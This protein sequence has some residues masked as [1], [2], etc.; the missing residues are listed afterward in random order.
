MI[1]IDKIE[2]QELRDQKPANRP[3]GPP[4]EV[5]EVE[6]DVYDRFQTIRSRA[7]PTAYILPPELEE[8]VALL[9]THGIKVEE[10]TDA[11]SGEAEQFLI[12]AHEQRETPYQGHCLVTL[13]GDYETHEMEF[14]QGS[15]V[16]CTDQPLCA[17]IFH[18]LEPESL[19]GVA[20]WDLLTTHLE[21]GEAYPIVKLFGNLEMRTSQ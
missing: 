21:A 17:L 15:F 19:D 12:E 3:P 7:L 13:E 14:P 4:E 16:V 1:L 6:M 8:T 5:V 20:A 10:T 18:I 11:W 2:T 9:K